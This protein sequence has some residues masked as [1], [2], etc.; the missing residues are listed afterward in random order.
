MSSQP[1]KVGEGFEEELLAEP[2][3]EEAAHEISEAEEADPCCACYED[4]DQRHPEGVLEEPSLQVV[5][6]VAAKG[7]CIVS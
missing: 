5:H 2:E 7:A 4:D 3:E 1:E 6:I